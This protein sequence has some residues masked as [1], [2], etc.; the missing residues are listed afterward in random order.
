MKTTII[1]KTI[2]KIAIGALVSILWDR[3]IRFSDLMTLAEFPLIFFGAFYYMLAWFNY[4]KL[5][6]FIKQMENAMILK[7]KESEKSFQ[8]MV[9]K[10]DALSPLKTMIRGFSIVEKDGKII[11]SNKDLKENDEVSIKLI[12]GSKNAKIM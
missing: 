12:D 9:S 11:K 3:Y 10:L 1:Q 5:D 8:N 2:T 4:L 7:Q 6:G